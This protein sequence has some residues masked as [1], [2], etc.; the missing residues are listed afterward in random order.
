VLWRGLAPRLR[1]L[2]DAAAHW[3]GGD[4]SY[5]AR[6]GGDDEVGRLAVAFDTMAE[7][8]Q[9][10][11]VQRELAQE[12][13]RLSEEHFRSLIEH[14]SDVI[15]VLDAQGAIN[16]VSPAIERVLGY[17]TGELVGRDVLELLHPDDVPVAA[18]ARAEILGHA[19]AAKAIEVR[20]RRQDGAWRV[21]EV[22]GR[23]LLNNTAFVGIVLN[24]RDVTERRAVERLKDEFASTVSHEIRTPMN[25]VIGMTGLLL[26]TA[27]TPQQREY[28]EAV[29]DSGEALLALINDILD[30]SKIEAGKVRLEVADL[31]V[32][33]VLDDVVEIL[34]PAAHAKGLEIVSFVH[35][36]VPAVVRGDAGRLRQVL[37]NLAGN[38][39]KFTDTGEVVIRARAQRA[40]A[41][42]PN[43]PGRV[44]FEVVDTGIGIPPDA[45]DRLF[46]TFSQLDSSDTRSHG[47][48]GLGLAICKRLVELM[49]GAIGVR[50]EPAWGSTFWFTVP[51]AA[52][53]T[54]GRPLADEDAL[55]GL[56]ALVVD[57]NPTN[58]RILKEQLASWGVS[59]TLAENGPRGLALLRSAAASG[60]RYD[61]ALLDMYMPGMSGAEVA[62][63]VRADPVLLSTPLIL[64]TSLGRD[65]TP[66]MARLDA[67]LTKPVRASRLRATLVRVLG[68]PGE[69][70]TPAGQTEPDNIPLP[71]SDRG[72]AAGRILVVE[73]TPIS[74]R[75]ALGILAKLGYAADAVANGRQALDALARGPY[76]AVLMDCQMP[77]MDGFAATAEVRRTEGAA[78]HTPI[79]AVTA[80]AMPGERERCLAAGMDDYVAKPFRAEEI[81]AALERWARGDPGGAQPVSP[82]NS[83]TVVAAPDAAVLDETALASLGGLVSD[84]GVELR[85]EVARLFAADTPVRVAA[86]RAAVASGDAAALA[87]AAHALKGEAGLIGAREVQA[88]ARELELLGRAGST[89]VSDL[90]L[91]RLGAAY[92]RARDALTAAVGAEP[93]QLAS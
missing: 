86:M 17:P 57:D 88:L 73:D 44:R 33:E 16:Y 40:A 3:S 14:S 51:L 31:E 5:R 38:A 23:Q 67:T 76:A 63:A 55:R 61:L 80:S 68:S 87:S 30:F 9:R 50:S 81:A 10:A 15:T 66:A 82:L 18:A 62:A 54:G 22:V 89:D 2:Q 64:L 13:L 36:D 43:V 46:Q 72:R 45:H 58:R 83:G 27:L 59:A 41:S 37:L 32:R 65:D 29:R 78:R 25:G 20:Y 56:R 60:T 79:I 42:A 21:L 8:L 39:I 52:S 34:A 93:R 49:G 75:L 71:A 7:R 11:E 70:V 85:R 28:A 92:E 90:V 6:I 4:W 69:L 12:A 48:S 35:R 24:S 84:Q 53:P 77:E 74:Q 47:G 26:D 1:A 19:E 91:A